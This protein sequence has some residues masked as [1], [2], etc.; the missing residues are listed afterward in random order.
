MWTLNDLVTTK[1]ETK[2]LQ[3]SSPFSKME[4]LGIIGGFGS[5]DNIKN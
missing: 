5:N 2:L 1:N 3:T 4:F